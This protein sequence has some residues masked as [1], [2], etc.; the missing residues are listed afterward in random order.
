MAALH[1][2]N[3]LS[4]RARILDAG[5]AGLVISWDDVL[6][7]GPVR[8][9]APGRF[10]A[11]RA[12]YIA[13]RGWALRAVALAGLEARDAALQSALDRGEEVALWFEDDLY[14]ALQLIQAISRI[15]RHV[16]RATWT[17]VPLGGLPFRGIPER[18]IE[19][20]TD[21]YAARA[22]PNGAGAY[23]VRVWDAFTAGD[24]LALDALAR[25]PAP[26]EAVPAALRRL[27]EELPEVT[28]RLGRTERVLLE[29]T[30]AGPITGLEAFVACAR[31]EKRPFLG[32]TVAFDRLD[33]LVASGLVETA[34]GG[35][36]AERTFTASARGRRVLA[37][38]ERAVPT[39]RWLGG[40][41]VGDPEG[42]HWSRARDRVVL[43]G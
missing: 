30:A 14:D 5:V 40:R 17:L 24:V 41:E 20:L 31:K 42:P 39:R 38:A 13:S 3:G 21:A 34:G 7:E 27:L 26:L 10:R 11:E 9:V 23:A 8:A 33:G 36:A 22:M 1:V 16:G 29:A 2:T 37:G 18:P 15:D 25:A 12:T 4:A 6:H 19:E 43:G 28:D 35:Y 32:D